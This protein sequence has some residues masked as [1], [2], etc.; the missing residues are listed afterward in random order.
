MN[1][2]IYRGGIKPYEENE[3]F[4]TTKSDRQ[5]SPDSV[6][7]LPEASPLPKSTKQKSTSQ[8]F[9]PT[10]DEINIE[11]SIDEIFLDVGK[12]NLSSYDEIEMI[13][14]RLLQ[15]ET[16]QFHGILEIP[17]VLSPSTTDEDKATSIG[18]TGT[19]SIFNKMKQQQKQQQKQNMKTNL[20][21]LYE[22]IKKLQDDKENLLERIINFSDSNDISRLNTMFV[23]ASKELLTLTDTYNQIIRVNRIPNIPKLNE[24]RVAKKKLGIVSNTTEPLS[25]QDVNKTIA[26]Q[27]RA[28]HSKITR[29]T[30]EITINA[31]KTEKN[32]KKYIEDFYSILHHYENSPAMIIHDREVSK[33]IFA[34]KNLKLE[35]TK[36]RETILQHKREYIELD[37]K[38]SEI[39]ELITDKIE[40]IKKIEG[41][42]KKDKE[43]HNITKDKL[44]KIQDKTQTTITAA[45]CNIIK[46]FVESKDITIATATKYLNVWKMNFKNMID[47]RKI[48]Y[49]KGYT[50]TSALTDNQIYEDVM[51]KINHKIFMLEL[52]NAFIKPVRG[53]LYVKV[54]YKPGQNMN[55]DPCH[56]FFFYSYKDKN[57]EI[58]KEKNKDFHLTIH[59][60]SIPGEKIEIY[61]FTQGK[62]H[63]RA[64]SKTIKNSANLLPH[65]FTK[66]RANFT[67]ADK[68][69]Q[70]IP[71]YQP[72]ANPT[73]EVIYT[74]RVV[75]E[76]LNDYLQDLQ[77]DL[78]GGTKRITDKKLIDDLSSFLIK[79]PNQY[80]KETLQNRIR[81][82]EDEV[83]VQKPILYEMIT[84]F[85]LDNFIIEQESIRTFLE[86]V[87]PINKFIR[88]QNI[89]IEGIIISELTED[90]YRNIIAKAN[91]RLKQLKIETT[92]VVPSHVPSQQQL[93]TLITSVSTGEVIP[94]APNMAVVDDAFNAPVSV[95]ASASTSHLPMFFWNQA[96]APASETGIPY[97]E[98]INPE[99][100]T[101]TQV[102]QVASGRKKRKIKYTKKRYNK[103]LNK[104]YNKVSNK[105]Y[106]KVS[107]K[108]GNYNKVSRK[109]YNKVSRK[110]G[111]Y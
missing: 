11:K 55:S 108:N 107:R 42:A 79:R 29:A 63:L 39:E 5:S 59:L 88:E 92:I 14:E 30:H 58:Q 78:L 57:A 111:N 102:T 45:D 38:M 41:A 89:Y 109:R 110:N 43:F 74:G 100:T 85:Y 47:T 34:L 36:S 76:T 46:S 80:L 106:N 50:Y 16:I 99:E 87:A 22:E 56:M 71:L 90:D 70:V 1:S 86:A 27:V 2:N 65:I 101:E 28:F 32:R 72:T 103:V 48:L 73:Q 13:R 4:R 66:R 98:S 9:E 64:D 61:D 19:V 51:S 7:L 26:Q 93:E 21:T 75:V 33:L 95:S 104:R 83:L 69:I 6:F 91:K 23:N 96:P 17:Y 68:C 53:N 24:D 44:T 67:G 10:S 35:I 18:G 8:R 97:L 37:E 81:I 25:V 3:K 49:L 20:G 82:L 15:L 60:G 12:Q 84:G 105:R 54:R 31:E 52:K 40:E 94:R 62:I 77:I